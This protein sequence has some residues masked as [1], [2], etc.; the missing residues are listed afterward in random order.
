[1]MRRKEKK[2]TSV[3]K[4]SFVNLCSITEIKS[5]STFSFYLFLI[6][7]FCLSITCFTLLRLN[8][9]FTRLGFSILVEVLEM[10]TLPLSFSGLVMENPSLYPL[11]M[12]AL[13]SKP[14]INT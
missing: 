9:V 1:M 11:A 5:V 2:K 10:L 4:M 14:R 13:S 3:F 8:I 7:S 6:I 12:E